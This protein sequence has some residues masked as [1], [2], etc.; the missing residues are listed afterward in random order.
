LRAARN[1]NRDVAA[2]EDCA[3][4]VARPF[5]ASARR[6]SGAIAPRNRR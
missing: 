1:G 3:L 6:T 4:N 2:V 5:I